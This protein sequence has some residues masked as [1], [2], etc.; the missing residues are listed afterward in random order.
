MGFDDNTLQTPTNGGGTEDVVFR[1]T[2]PGQTEI[3][4]N[5]QRNVPTGQFRVQN[6]LFV[7]IF[8]TVTEKVVLRPFVPEQEIV[9]RFPGIPDRERE[10]SVVSSLDVNYQ[11]QWAKGRKAFTMDARAGV[12]YYWSR[13]KDPIEY[14]ASLSMQYIRRLS[15]RMQLSTGLSA[16]YQTQPDFTRLNAIADAD[17]SGS[18]TLAS[19]K[20]DLSYRWN[21]RLSTVTS[22][23]AD[24]RLQEA[25]SGSGS[26]TSFGL[27]QE[28]RYLWSPRLTFVA[29]TRYTLVDYID[30]ESSNKTLSLLIGADW[31]ISR[32]FRA[33]TRVG[34]SVRTF[35]PS[36]VTSS[37]P[38]GELALN[39]QPSRRN[40]FTLS[41]RYGFEE[42]SIPG[43]E[44][45]VFRSS[46]SYQRLF[47]PR[48]VGSLALNKISYETKNAAQSS[49]Q[50]VLDASL[51]LR[52]VISRKFK[53]GTSF[54][55][56]NSKT[57]SGFSDYYRN[58]F[59][60][61]GEY[62]F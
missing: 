17:V 1:Q 38:F 36:G 2:I 53:M 30:A 44:Q 25:T 26:F 45:L 57:D 27:G 54:S 18:Y 48:L 60:V 14:E 55:Y 31:D 24:I 33:T 20:T 13:S 58:R 47:N 61:T 22:F 62:E 41:S 52:Y 23:N 19:S 59:M 15:S 29:D 50:D 37:A 11:A 5:V 49:N 6:G 9:Q 43:S 35:Q 16:S 34:E 3:S 21:R 28:I 12:D 46:L 56:T 39:Y 32:R 7:P 51:N 40:T 10:G 8:R 42:S 4:Q